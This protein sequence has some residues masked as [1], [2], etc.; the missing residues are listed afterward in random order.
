MDVFVVETPLQLVNAIEAKHYFDSRHNALIV[1]YSADYPIYK[2]MSLIRPENWNKIE[3]FCISKT[4][5][6]VEHNKQDSRFKLFIREYINTFHQFCRRRN[7]EKLCQN[8]DSI[9]KLFI[10][11]YIV[12]HMRHLAK[13]LK[14][15]SLVVL[16]DGTDTI[17]ANDRRRRMNTRHE[18]SSPLIDFRTIRSYVRNRY[19]DWVD[20]DAE[21]LTFFS[22]YELETS[23]NDKFISNNYLYLKEKANSQHV[24]SEVFF[25]GQPLTEDG[26]ITKS[27]YHELLKFARNHFQ[28]YEFVYLPH[29]RESK[30]SVAEVETYLRYPIK[31]F[32]VPVEVA[33]ITGATR[34]QFLAS[35]FSTAL[36]NC[37]IIF[38]D[39]IHIKAFH[40]N[41]KDF[42]PGHDFVKDTY[43]YLA[44]K[45]SPKFEIFEL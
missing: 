44:R 23:I 2:Y 17:R 26:Y 27:R 4:I 8:Y 6:R 32:D 45:M 31:R 9:E 30:E 12:D 11:N 34:P 1:L 35:F 25:L 5:Y 37:R 24:T 20:Y 38:G 14:H 42:Y 39:S 13:H 43:Q 40:I 36:D 15:R 10:G 41:Q 33:L 21:S 3:F 22:S 18:T 29:P 16:D 7:L 19:I 28:D